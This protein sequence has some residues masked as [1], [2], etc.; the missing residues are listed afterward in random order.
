MTC[1]GPN[2]CLSCSKGTYL[3]SNSKLCENC[4]SNCETCE[5]NNI[6]GNI[7][8]TCIAPHKYL[9]KTKVCVS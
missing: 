8:K 6:K 9:Q 4:D 5:D 7:C 1:D 2:S 3:N